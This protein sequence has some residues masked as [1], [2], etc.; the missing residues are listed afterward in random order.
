M[1][2]H[3]TKDNM[4]TTVGEFIFRGTWTNYNQCLAWRDLK[5]STAYR[6]VFVY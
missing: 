4:K 6:S 1:R 2:A 3:Q 5:E